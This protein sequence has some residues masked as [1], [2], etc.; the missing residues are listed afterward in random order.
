MRVKTIKIGKRVIGE[1]KPCYI[2]AEIGS[3]HNRDL[4]LAKKIIRKISK[5]GADA[6][7]FQTFKAATLVNKVIRP[8]AYRLL[9]EN[10]LPYE[11][12][13][14]L[15]KYAE[16]YDLTFLSTPFDFNAVDLLAGLNVSAYKIASGDLTHLPLIK[17]I[18]RLGKPI[19]MSAG[20]ADNKLIKSA[21]EVIR[22]QGNEKIVVCQCT[23]NYP[24]VYKDVNVRVLDFLKEE[25]GVLSGFS[26]HSIGCLA[27]IV[28][29][30]RGASVVEKHVTLRK[31][32]EGPDHHFAIEIDEFKEL[33]DK[34]RTVET[35]LGS[36]NKKVL[37]SER[38][39]LFTSRRSI[40]AGIDMKRGDKITANKL[41]I[42][43]PAVELVPGKHDR[44]I[45][46]RILRSK[47]KYEPIYG[48]DVS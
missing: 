1:G 36:S 29:V 27:S 17:Y 31:D 15:K 34:I 2:I 33:V 14:I 6:V 13:K 18:A 24:A 30:A 40:Y 48:K 11:W 22:K 12:H 20:A 5:T 19:I 7:K 46:R 38:K 10:E 21:I 47:K 43:R 8:D 44:I 39:S 41:L 37:L 35:I 16:K 26:D 23:V 9:E 42:L 28:A 45:G 4:K 25:Y 3:N 32:M